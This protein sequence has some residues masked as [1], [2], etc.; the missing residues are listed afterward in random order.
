[1]FKR[2]IFIFHLRCILVYHFHKSDRMDIINM[3]LGGGASSTLEAACLSA[4]QNGLLLVAAAG[5]SG[6]PPG[7][8]D[9]IIYPAAYESVIAV[10]ATDQ[11]DKRASWS[12]TGPDLELSAPGVAINSTLLGGGYGEKS[13]TSMASPHVAGTAALVITAG[14]SDVRGQ[15]QSTAKDLGATGWDS[16][17]GWGLV[18][19]FAALNWTAVPNNPP[20][21][22]N[23]SVII[24]EDT[25][26]AITLTATDLDSDP[27]TYFIVSQPLNGSVS[28]IAPDV[29]YTPNLNYNGSDSFTFKA[30]DGKVDS[31]IATVSITINPVNDAPVANPQSVQTPQD[32]PIAITLTGSDVDNDALTFI[33]A[34]IPV[35][36]MLTGTVPNLTYTPKSGFI[37]SDNF[38]FKVNDGLVDSNIATVSITVTPT[39]TPSNTMHVHNIDMSFKTAG[40]NVNA[41]AAVTIYDAID[42]PVGGATVS[43]HWSGATSDTDSG[44][45]NDSGIVSLESNKVKNPKS[46]TTFT[47]TV[48]DVI[49]DGWTYDSPLEKPS[50]SITY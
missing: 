8:G 1:S 26:V 34:T 11:N 36:G 46:G 20:V 14:I 37:G 18:D 23:Q 40:I 12:S 32:T 27:L 2:C 15:L 4:N 38:T 41:I 33:L 42:K 30:N 25:P 3:S 43:G 22:D 17:Y 5:N 24:N 39:M 9:N 48:D 28:G 10:A 16:K 31:N 50:N 29:S 19:A 45:T 6:N 21:A 7:K 35:N 47:F 13:G 44:V 49:K